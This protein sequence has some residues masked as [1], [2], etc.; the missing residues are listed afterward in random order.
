MLIHPLFSQG[1][2]KQQRRTI[3]SK[4]QDYRNKLAALDS[5]LKTAESY[6]RKLSTL[7]ENFCMRGAHMYV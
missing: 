5:Q 2:Y 4:E 7:N 1:K 3:K 6:K